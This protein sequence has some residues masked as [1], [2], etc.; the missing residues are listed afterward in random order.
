MT[1]SLSTAGVW[2][3]LLLAHKPTS[4]TSRPQHHALLIKPAMCSACQH[5]DKALLLRMRLLLLLHAGSQARAMLP[6]TSA[7]AA[8]TCAREA[9]T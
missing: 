2:R 1:T 7:A 4:S 3:L 8:R 5:H 6:G 9:W